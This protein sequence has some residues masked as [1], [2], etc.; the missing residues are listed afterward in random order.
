MRILNR[1]ESD[2]Y[3]SRR[4]GGDEGVEAFRLPGFYDGFSTGVTALFLS[5]SSRWLIRLVRVDGDTQIFSDPLH[6]PP[7]CRQVGVG[8]LYLV[9]VLWPN[10]EDG[11]HAVG[12][13]QS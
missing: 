9:D 6:V 1:V 5:V 4:R 7:G 2:P 12:V 11:Q 8:T 10:F 3:S 13:S